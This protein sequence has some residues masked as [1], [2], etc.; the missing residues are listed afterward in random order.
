MTTWL[1]ALPGCAP[2]IR[3]TPH[4]FIIDLYCRMHSKSN[5][6]W[7]ISRMVGWEEIETIEWVDEDDS[8]FKAFL[9]TRLR[10][11]YNLMMEQQAEAERSFQVSGQ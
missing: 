2:T 7:Q 11:A 8:I 6:C 5:R 4:S 9:D 10:S 3:T 1:H